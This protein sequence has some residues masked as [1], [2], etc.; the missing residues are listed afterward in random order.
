M[1]SIQIGPFWA[2]LILGIVHVYTCTCSVVSDSVT[3]WTAA[4]QAFLSFTISWSMLKLVSIELVE[5]YSM[6]IFASGFS[7]RT[8]LRLILV[9][10]AGT[11]FL[12]MQ[13]IFPCVDMPHL[14]YPFS[15]DAYRF[16]R[17][18]WV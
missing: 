9:T 10:R 3:P 17:N 14:I 1:L 5:L 11:A 18:S 12:W 2:F 7:L 6:W 13:I 4:C 15:C 8:F 16:L